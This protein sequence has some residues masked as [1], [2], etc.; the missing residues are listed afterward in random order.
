M[1]SIKDIAKRLIVMFPNPIPAMMLGSFICPAKLRF[2]DSCRKI[3]MEQRIE[4]TPI[5]KK[6]MVLAKVDIVTGGAFEPF[7]NSG[8]PYAYDIVL[9]KF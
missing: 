5:L 9:T 1:D 8:V 7:S 4:G 2:I 6:Y 3:T